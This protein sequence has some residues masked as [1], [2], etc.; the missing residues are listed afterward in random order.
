[1]KTKINLKAMT[2][3]MAISRAD[4]PPQE[5]PTKRAGIV[6]NG[7]T[8]ERV[9]R[10]TVHAISLGERINPT[11]VVRLAVLDYD[12]KQMTAAKIR[13]LRLQDR[14]RTPVLLKT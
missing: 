11:D 5:E 1:M 8:L 2:D 9:N 7:A 6:L 4:I 13:A 14:R 12:E 10:L 3:N